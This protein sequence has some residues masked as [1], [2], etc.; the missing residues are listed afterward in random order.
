MIPGGFDDE[1]R[2]ERG[3]VILLKRRIAPSVL[4]IDQD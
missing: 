3:D 2:G 4:S 1:Y